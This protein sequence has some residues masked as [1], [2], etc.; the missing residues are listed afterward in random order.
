MIVFIEKCC[1]HFENLK[2]H[3]VSH[4]ILTNFV[5]TQWLE[6]FHKSQSVYQQINYMLHANRNASTA[7]QVV[8]LLSG[9]I[10][11]RITLL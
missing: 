5:S 10:R 3:L 9:L 6:I 1:L 7:R 11:Y 2:V 4:R 8:H